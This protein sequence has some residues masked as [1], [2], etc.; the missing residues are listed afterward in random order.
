ML[1]NS[2][3]NFKCNRDYTPKA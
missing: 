1:L 3:N 2:R